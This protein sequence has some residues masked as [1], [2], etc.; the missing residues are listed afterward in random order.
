MVRAMPA[1]RKEGRHGPSYVSRHAKG[2]F[3]QG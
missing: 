1:G 2:G 3:S